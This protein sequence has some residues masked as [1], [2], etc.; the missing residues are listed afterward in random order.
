MEHEKFS[1]RTRTQTCE[2][3]LFPAWEFGQAPNFGKRTVRPVITIHMRTGMSQKI[4]DT[5]PQS[6]FRSDYE[7]YEMKK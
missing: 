5:R 4:E 7:K 1:H 6:Q 3:L 2:S